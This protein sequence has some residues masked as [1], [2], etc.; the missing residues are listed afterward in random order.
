[1]PQILPATFLPGAKQHRPRDFSCSWMDTL[2]IRRAYLLRRPFRNQS[3]HDMAFP[4]PQ[5]RQNHGRNKDIARLEGVAR[6]LVER[7]IN[8]AE[9]RNAEN[10]VNPAEN[11]AREASIRDVRCSP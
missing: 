4:H 2:R 1:M 7:A 8:I 9:D 11:R 10:D 3:S 6:K 5:S